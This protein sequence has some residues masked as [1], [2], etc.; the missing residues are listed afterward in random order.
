MRC[1]KYDSQKKKLEKGIVNK[2]GRPVW[3]VSL[4][5]EKIIW[6]L[7]CG[8]AALASTYFIFYLKC[9]HCLWITDE[10]TMIPCI[11]RV[12]EK[13]KKMRFFLSSIEGSNKQNKKWS[14]PF[15][16]VGRNAVVWDFENSYAI[17]FLI[18]SRKTKML[19]LSLMLLLPGRVCLNVRHVDRQHFYPYLQSLSFLFL[20]ANVF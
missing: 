8:W 5:D 14:V 18:F 19:L 20:F 11:R 9:V 4:A 10:Q 13:K 3:H 2:K 17:I 1:V 6:L 12:F 15:L 16:I 7:Q